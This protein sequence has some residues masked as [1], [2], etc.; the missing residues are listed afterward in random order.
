MARTRIWY[1]VVLLVAGFA[2]AGCASRSGVTADATCGDY[3]IAETDARHAAAVR[4]S[5]ELGA[6][7]AGNPMWGTGLDAECGSAPDATLRTYFAGQLALEQGSVSMEPTINSGDTVVVNTLAYRR[8]GPRRGEV[9][10]FRA[11]D[12]WRAGPDEER[13]VKRVVATGGDHVTCCDT[14]RRLLVNG[15]PLDEPYLHQD[16]GRMDRLDVLVP[17]GRLWLMGDYRSHSYDSREALLRFGDVVQATIPVDA[18][19][20]RVF[21]V[22]DAHDRDTVRWLAVP[23]TYADVP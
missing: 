22:I 1:L 2:P 8:S 20:G 13:F 23:P 7:R 15:H 18:M 10:L 6:S 11:P 4:L 19:V 16:P 14:Q 5:T 17:D 21:V 3:L 12:S 9:V